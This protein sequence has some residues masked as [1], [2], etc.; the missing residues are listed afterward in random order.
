VYAPASLGGE[1]ARAAL[2]SHL[3][4]VPADE[5][6]FC[7]V[8]LNQEFDA[9]R[10]MLTASTSDSYAYLFKALCNAGDSVLLPQ[11]SY[12]L[13][14]HLAALEGV[15]AV[16]YR[17][18]YD[19]AW[20]VDWDSVR[21][22][23]GS[24][25]KAIVIVTP[26]NPTASCLTSDEFQTFADQ[27]VPLIVDQVFAPFV[28]RSQGANSLPYHDVGALTFVLDGL[29]K[30]C[31]LPQL[32]VGWIGVFGPRFAV[33]SAMAALEMIG[34]T[35][36]GVNG[37]A[38]GAL[39]SILDAT[40]ETRRLI[41]AR[42][43][44][45]LEHLDHL[46]TAGAPVSPLHYQGGWSTLLRLPNYR[47]DDEWAHRLLKR[48]V[49]LQPGWLYDCPEPATLVLSLL[50]QPS[51]FERGLTQVL[52]AVEDQEGISKFETLP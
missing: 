33:E 1:V 31:A 18:N 11:P 24:K 28:R 52:E 41:R 43:A 21:S 25:P 7:D 50:A 4:Q 32:K 23:L 30:R 39:A 13:L 6:G 12:P 2:A 35:Y 9:S 5:H 26:N 48:G 8:G 45:N 3:R 17:L 38:E 37:I 40:N 49:I 36:L 10:L 19:G 34:D 16:P 22:G 42:L 29:S 14:E 44:A 20:H 47:T 51:S 46:K 27:G 15:R